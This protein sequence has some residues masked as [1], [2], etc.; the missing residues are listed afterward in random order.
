[1]LHD[2]ERTGLDK[3]RCEY[4]PGD[5]IEAGMIIWRVGKDYIIAPPAILYK[6]EHV[7]LYDTEIPVAQFLFDTADE[8]DLRLSHLYRSH[9]RSSAR[10]EFKCHRTCAGEEIAYRQPLHILDILYDIEY[11]FAGEIGCGPG[12]YI[13][14][15]LE[16]TPPV[17]PSDYPHLDLL[18]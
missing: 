7:T 11:V 18:I 8:A 2:Q 10:Q 14:R 5:L 17:F 16:T 4:Q 9:L 15:G 12:R 3:R 1:M 13:L 6:F